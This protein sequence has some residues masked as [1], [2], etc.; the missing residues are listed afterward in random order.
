VNNLYCRRCGRRITSTEEKCLGC[1]Y[2]TKHGQA[3][4][5]G[6]LLTRRH[7]LVV[8]SVFLVLFA[9]L[10]LWKVGTCS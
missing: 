6:R 7:W 2:P 10:V 1:G 4:A 3:A 8:V 5:A 9:L